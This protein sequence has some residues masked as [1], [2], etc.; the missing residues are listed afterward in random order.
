[1]DMV[2]RLDSRILLVWPRT[3]AGWYRW[4]SCALRSS[5]RRSRLGVPMVISS[6]EQITP[7]WLTARLTQQGLLQR[8]SVRGLRLADQSSDRGTF[9][10]TASFEVT[11]TED[12]QGAV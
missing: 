12:T 4:C 3:S 9:A 10:N 8:G 6:P 5:H 7:E 11:Y 1:M 2:A